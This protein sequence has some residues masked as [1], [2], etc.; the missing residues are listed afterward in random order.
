MRPRVVVR[1]AALIAALVLLSGSADSA[2]AARSRLPRNT[3]ST[4]LQL[5]Q[6][7]IKH[8]VFLI[9]ENRT[10]D[11]LFG[12]FPG[13]D[14]ATMGKLCQ[15]NKTVPL[16]KMTDHAVDIAHDFMAGLV[17]IDDGRMD[18]NN[19]LWEHNNNH[20]AP[21]VQVTDGMAQIPSYW[22]YA[23]HF[24][25]A[26][27]FFSSI[28]GPSGPEHLWTVAGS[29]AG[30]IDHEENAKH[31]SIGTGAPREYCDDTAERATA[32]PSGTNRTDPGIMNAEDP[33]AHR[34]VGAVP[35]GRG[36]R[37]PAGRVVADP[38]ARRLGPPAG[39]PVPG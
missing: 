37:E 16:A 4:Q 36:G 1:A 34:A 5:A 39:Q 28:Y 22:T 14:G 13:A 8:V 17:A 38:A 18:C 35:H 6:S 10:F 31:D 9:K 27:E 23:S 2:G 11:N 26:D 33:G 30:I 29:S 25:L 21:Y 7:H 12:R 32:F 19:L 20:M 15:P 3:A 24:E